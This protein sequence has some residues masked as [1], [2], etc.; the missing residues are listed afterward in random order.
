MIENAQRVKIIEFK[1][2]N[3]NLGNLKTCL[4][5]GHTFIVTF[6]ITDFMQEWFTDQRLMQ[7]SF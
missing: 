7:N 1:D 2:M 3:I 5:L 6:N 4:N